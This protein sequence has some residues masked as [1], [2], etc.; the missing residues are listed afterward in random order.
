MQPWELRNSSG[1]LAFRFWF[2]GGQRSLALIGAWGW[3]NY[4]A[5]PSAES[6]QQ[7]FSP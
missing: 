1:F 5:I 2:T 6:A 3:L 4:L 7:I